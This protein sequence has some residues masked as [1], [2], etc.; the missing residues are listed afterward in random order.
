[1][2]NFMPSMTVLA[3]HAEGLLLPISRLGTFAPT[4]STGTRLRSQ[5]QSQS[6]SIKCI[7]SR[8]T[9][10][11]ANRR[12]PLKWAWAPV[13]IPRLLHDARPEKL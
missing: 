13:A 10:S 2:S 9:T 11:G 7:F 6:P 8:L 1:M 12:L 5:S 4:A 3:S